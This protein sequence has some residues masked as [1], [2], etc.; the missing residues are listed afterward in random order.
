MV[1]STFAML[2]NNLSQLGVDA[3]QLDS[4]LDSRFDVSCL[5]ATTGEFGRGLRGATSATER[6]GDA[7]RNTLHPSNQDRQSQPDT[8]AIENS[9]IR[10]SD[11]NII[12]TPGLFAPE[13]P[14]SPMRNMR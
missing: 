11:G 12:F 1:W 6:D 14:R 13:H 3:G 7:H 4:G 10:T 8:E 2:G 5:D 9:Q